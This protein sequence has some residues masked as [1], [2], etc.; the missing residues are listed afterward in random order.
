MMRLHRVYSGLQTAGFYCCQSAEMRS[1]QLCWI[2]LFARLQLRDEDRAATQQFTCSWVVD[3][4]SSVVV[5]CL[6]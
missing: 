1:F 4:T 5:V 6:A 2:H 3:F